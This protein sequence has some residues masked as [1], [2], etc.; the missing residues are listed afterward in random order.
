MRGKIKLV[1]FVLCAV[2]MFGFAAL[3]ANAQIVYSV[4]SNPNEVVHYGVTEVMGRFRLE[5]T[6]TGPSIG[7]T[8]TITY[9]GV[10]I[11]NPSSV[12]TPLGGT[13]APG[14]I[15]VD[16]SGAFTAAG[17]TFTSV[18]STGTGGQVI[19]NIPAGISPSGTANTDTIVIDGVRADVSTKSVGTDIIASI[20]SAP[21][22]ANTFSN[23]SVLRVATINE[24]LVVTVDAASDPICLTPTNPTITVTEGSAGVFVQYVTSAAGSAIPPDAR[25]LFGANSNTRVNIVLTPLPD[26]TTLAWPTTVT[27]DIDGA[28]AGTDSS[29]LE[30]ISQSTSGDSALYEYVT[31][32][33]GASDA[34]VESFAITPVVTIDPD[35]ALPGTATVQAQLYP[36]NPTSATAVPRFNHPLIN[37]PAD[38]FLIISKCTT[39]LL[40]PF[41]TN[42][43]GS[44]FDSGYAIMNTSSDPYGTVPQAGTITQYFYGDAAPAAITSPS[45]AA[46]TLF[47]A[48]ISQVAPGF[49]GYMIAICEFQFGHGFAFITGKYNAG[50]VFDVA[51]GYVANVIPDPGFNGGVRLPAVPTSAQNSGENLGN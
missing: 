25:A 44:G 24:S 47:A 43:V 16:G 39:N 3:T 7:S 2:F 14:G 17:I 40:F 15:T 10:T 34:N 22:T 31:E 45:V 19:I 30:L 23:T 48:V 4:S 13:E 46:G 11:T 6:N 50:S 12:A 51:E 20:S 21:S 32:L 1:S 37:S 35:T 41:L 5:A 8:V 28:G 33:Q 18:A 29:F 26:G 27:I 38:T 49:Q 36:P 9:Q 42:S